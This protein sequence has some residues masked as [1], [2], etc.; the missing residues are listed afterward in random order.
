MGLLYHMGRV[1]FVFRFRNFTPKANTAVN[2]AIQCAGELGHTYIGSEHLLYGLLAEGSGVASYLLA[3]KQVQPAQL[4]GMLEHSIGKGVPVPL[5]PKEFTPRCKR[6]LERAVFQAQGVNSPLAGTEHILI[7]LLMESDSYAVRFLGEL[8]INDRELSRTLVDAMGAEAR[9]FYSSE[10]AK[11]AMPKQGAKAVKTPVLD[12]YSKDLTE[13]ARQKKLDPV[14]GREKEVQRVLRILSRRSKN[15]PCLVGEA[16]VGKTAV[17]EAIALK[18]AAGEVPAQL[19][20]KRLVA[21]DL[22]AMVAGTKYRGDFEERVRAVL[23]EVEAAGNVILFIDELHNIM[24]IGAAEGAVDAANILKPQLARGQL[25]MI[26]ATTL[27]EYRRHIEKDS[28]LERRF[29][30]VRIEEPAP[31][32]AVAILQGLRPQYERH[33]GLKITDEAI[34]AA[35]ELS[36]RYLTEHRLPDK[37]LDLLDEAASKVRMGELFLPRELADLQERLADLVQK[38]EQAIQEQQFELAARLRDEQQQVQQLQQQAAEQYTDMEGTQVTAEDVAEVVTAITGIDVRR[39][40]QEQSCYLAQLEEKL[41][42]RI[43]GQ[44]EAVSAVARA[45]RRGRIGLGDPGRPVGSFLFLGPTGVGKTELS[46]ALAQLLFG[47]EKALIRL[48]M[49]E[50]MEKQSVSRLVGSPPGY[51]GY[52]D[53]GQLTEKVRRQPY[54]VVLLDEVEKA[55]PDVF[56]ILLQVL[57][58]GILTDS[59]GRQVDFKNT[60]LILTSNIGAK[61]ITDKQQLGFGEQQAASAKQVRQAVLRELKKEFR[62]EF[63]NRLDELIVF[64]QLGRQD[65]LQ[66]AQ[67][68]VAQ[69]VQRAAKLGITLHPTQELLEKLAD[70]GES[71][72]YGARPIRRAVQ[73]SL[74][75]ALADAVLD[76]SVSAG[77]SY[78]CTVSSQGKVCFI[79]QQADLL[80]A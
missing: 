9:Q 69:S 49:S 28:A 6:I 30:S 32:Q 64:E 26:G 10:A 1:V 78:T 61:E 45:V 76:G 71:S 7:S 80:P 60:V 21:L 8:G 68:I 73:T 47:T 34:Q 33:H 54:S 53:G 20:G 24:G 19:L 70:T 79:Q 77:K 17:A 23:Q 11:Q 25:Q 35:V 63:L 38:K 22:A 41:H 66:I 52:E 3:A 56:H 59:Q 12:R 42:Q 57:E 72:G 16:G 18:I 62:P 65:F 39:L 31:E 51:V 37:A 2:L 44:Q 15:N 27:E 75:D 4:H 36:V 55:H 58:D 50:Y 46:K 43:V 67:R 29:Q 74:E 5:S 48:D 14:I 40:N 13:F